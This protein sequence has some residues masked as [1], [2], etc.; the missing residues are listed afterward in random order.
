M[1]V[2]HQEKNVAT[3][4]EATSE[5]LTVIDNRTRQ[6]YELPITDRTIRASDRWD[7]AR[8]RGNSG[9]HLLGSDHHKHRHDPARPARAEVAVPAVAGTRT[10]RG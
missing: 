5:S 4:G 8:A 10:A 2:M 1:R 9:R 6:R 3:A 7:R